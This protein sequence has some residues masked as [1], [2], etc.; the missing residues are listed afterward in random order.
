MFANRTGKI[1]L[2][3]TLVLATCALLISR[4]TTAVA[5]TPSDDELMATFDADM[6]HVVIRWS[7]DDDRPEREPWTFLR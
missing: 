4:S 2:C 3:G 7:E 6:R 5:T 1:L